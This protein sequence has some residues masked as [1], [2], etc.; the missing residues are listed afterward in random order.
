MPGWYVESLAGEGRRS[1]GGSG[2]QGWICHSL[3][4]RSTKVSSSSS[5]DYISS[6]IGEGHDFGRGGQF[7]FL[8]GSD[9]EVKSSFR[10]CVQHSV[11]CGEKD[12]I[13]E[14]DFGSVSIK[15]VDCQNKIQN[16]DYR[17]S[18]ILHQKRG[19]VHL[20]RSKRCLSPDPHCSLLQEIPSLQNQHRCVAVQSSSVR[21]NVFPTSFHKGD[22]SSCSHDSFRGNSL[23]D[24]FGRLVDPRKNQGGNG[25][26]H[27]EGV[28]FVRGIGDYDQSPEVDLGSFSKNR[29]SGDYHRL[30]S[31]SSSPIIRKNIENKEKSSKFLIKPFPNSKIMG[32][33]VGVTS[34]STK[35]SSLWQIKDQS[36]TNRSQKP[37]GLGPQSHVDKLV[38]A[39]KE[40]PIMV[41]LR[42]QA[43]NRSRP[44][45]FRTRRGILVRRLGRWMGSKF[46]NRICKS[47]LVRRRDMSS[48]K[49]KGIVSR[50]KRTA[51]FPRVYSRKNSSPLLRQYNSYSL[52]KK[53]RGPKIRIVKQDS[54]KNSEM[55]G[56]ERS[57]DHSSIHFRREECHSRRSFKTRSESTWGMVAVSPGF[58]K[59][60][61]K[62]A[63]HNR[64][65]CNKPKPQIRPVLC[66][67]ERRGS[68]R[69][70]WSPT[71]LEPST[72]ICLPTVC[73]NSKSFSQTKTV[74]GSRTN[75]NCTILASEV[76]VSR[77]FGNVDRHSLV[78]TSETKATQ[79]ATE[80]QFSQKIRPAATSCLE[81]VKR[82]AR[83]EGFSKEVAEIFEVSRKR[84]TLNLYNSRWKYYAEWCQE[85]GK[86][87]HQPSIQRIA[88]F[89]VYLWKVKHR[90]HQ[91]ITGFRSM[92]SMVFQNKLPNISSHYVIR[93]I[94]RAANIEAPK[95]NNKITWDLIKVL[96]HLKKLEPLSS[97]NMRSLTKKTL[98]LVALATCKRVG[99]LRALRPNYVAQGN[100]IFVSYHFWFTAKTESKSR[101]IPRSFMIKALTESPNVPEVGVA[102]CPVRAL[103]IY[104]R[105]VRRFNSK[106]PSLF[107]APSNVNRII[108]KNAISALLRETI[109]DAK[110]IIDN[111]G[112]GPRAHDIRG[113]SVSS[114]YSKNVSIKDILSAA[115]WSSPTVFTNFYL[116]DIAFHDKDLYSLG[117]FVAAGNIIE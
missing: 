21:I 37:M 11:S 89:L 103:K 95:P 38:K 24:V 88:D 58:Q 30:H 107:V 69:D 77:D 5:T 97:L 10:G 19:L 76:M 73:S 82:E 84:S 55:V 99:E 96:D 108:S 53:T 98:F 6:G 75:L 102:L 16:A 8:Q 66:T 71:R 47:L 15:P 25:M 51:V 92:F 109:I 17:D 94:I 43:R 65:I 62:M 80:I 32:K 57:R 36:F 45:Y 39:G 46:N 1:L 60:Q 111:Q 20:N 26:G 86:D 87:P 35:S 29:L 117:P 59:Y 106:P 105:I 40:R 18:S 115:C 90:S 113:A 68:I 104:S 91:V 28:G 44:K 33:N 83:K 49:C 31:F 27:S 110:A 54:P 23:S 85:R 34:F 4:D 101:P 81:A 14:T 79:T 100:S 7:S 22:G 41:G 56:E 48:H 3:G 9:R 116:K 61:Q 72:T 13:L 112:K 2:S 114:A 12:G 70:G 64:S 74:S 63:S 78:T 67:N 93:H 50:R 42:K 52:P